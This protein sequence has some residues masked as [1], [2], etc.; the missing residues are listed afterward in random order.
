MPAALFDSQGCLTSGAF[1]RIATAPPGGAPS[2]L[3][4][5][6]ASCSRCQKRLLA[7]AMGPAGA[8]RPRRERPPLWRTAVAVIA[9]LL[10]VM[11][12]MVMLQ[13]VAGGR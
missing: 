2:E 12:A 5:H 4:S 11:V 8:P 7:S 9:C 3:A 1:A 13:V 10:L 6:L